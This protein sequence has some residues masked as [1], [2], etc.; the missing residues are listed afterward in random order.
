MAR[1]KKSVDYSQFLDLDDDDKDFASSPPVSKKARLETKKE[2]KEKPIKKIHKEEV[3][4]APKDSPKNRLPLDD[5]LYQRDLEVALALSVKET[6]VII[7]ND[8]NVPRNEAP[9]DTYTC[10]KDNDLSE[11]SFSNCSVNS[12]TLGLD[13]ITDGNEDSSRGRDRRQAASKAITEQR[14]LLKEESGDEE[15]E[16][17]FRPDTVEDEDSESEASLSDEDDELD[18]LTSKKPSINKVVKEK[19]KSG[20]K[21]KNNSKAQKA[22]KEPATPVTIKIKPMP[23]KKAP[24][25]SPATSKPPSS[26]SSPPVGMN[27]TAWTPPASSGAGRSPLT[28]ITIRSPNQGLRLGL[29]RLARVKP[30]HPTTAL[31]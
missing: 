24:V 30:L 19:P 11:V 2:K 17:E 25:S 29:S 20:K 12:S 21:E 9:Q 3:H 4:S 10:I 8:E 27:R 13:E 28:G 5:K 23:A 14:K 15:E 1:N 26:H 31:H 18:F 6:S 7:E 16:E 22:A